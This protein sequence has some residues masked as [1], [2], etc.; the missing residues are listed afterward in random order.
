MEAGSDC[1]NIHTKLANALTSSCYYLLLF[2]SF[3]LKQQHKYQ[4][5]AFE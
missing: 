3:C 2:V 5:H 1:N 4:Y